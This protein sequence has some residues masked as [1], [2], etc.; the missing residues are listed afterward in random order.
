MD[1]F[2]KYVESLHVDDF[3]PMLSDGH[4]P[5]TLKLK[6]KL[7]QDSNALDNAEKP[8]R[9]WDKLKCNEFVNNIDMY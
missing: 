8:K 3:C 4:N 9:L 5:V 1:F 6:V 2:F 7:R